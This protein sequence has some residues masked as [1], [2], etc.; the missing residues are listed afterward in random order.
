MKRLLFSAF[1]VTTVA[2]Q[3]EAQY[4]QHQYG[5]APDIGTTPSMGGVTTATGPGHLVAG[6]HSRNLAGIPLTGDFGI[7]VLRTD[8]GGRFTSP[9]NFNNSYLFT[10]GS[11]MEL[12]FTNGG[13][14]VEYPD[15]S[16]YAVVGTYFHETL[17]QNQGIAFIKLDLNGN[18]VFAKAYK[19]PF[20]TAAV[21]LSTSALK[22]STSQP[23]HFIA[24]GQ[25]GN[26][27][28]NYLWAIHFDQNGNLVWGGLYDIFTVPEQPGDLVESP[29]NN[30]LLI[31]GAYPTAGTQNAFMLVLNKITGAVITAN[32][33]SA[34]A[35]ATWESLRSVDVSNDPASPG[36][37]LA[38]I[39]DSKPWVSKI[40]PA[41]NFMWS[42]RYQPTSIPLGYM[43]GYDVVGR[44]NSLNRYEY[45]VTGPV[46]EDAYIM[47]LNNVGNP[48]TN[49]LFVYDIGVEETGLEVD[50]KNGGAD[51]G[52]TMYAVAEDDPLRQAYIVKAY[53]N[54]LSGCNEAFTNVSSQS[55]QFSAL[56]PFTCTTATVLNE[57]IFFKAIQTNAD[58][59][60]CYNTTIP[61]GSNARPE[62]PAAS[63]A[64]F[65][66][67]PLEL[68]TGSG[69]IQVTTETATEAQVM[70]CDMVGKV[71]YQ[72]KFSLRAG[73]NELP[74]DLSGSGM[75]AGLYT[76]K[77][78]GGQ[79]NTSI[80][81]LVK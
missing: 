27:M 11:G 19:M 63:G 9:Q 62:L 68:K 24:T 16:G 20:S 44:L 32:R 56:T 67:N 55:L 72:N 76:V 65:T 4:F 51:A 43:Y 31:V 29:Y 2:T 48:V 15:G 21:N 61:G 58:V 18:V 78:T 33:M 39:S 70:I 13:H 8:A 74:V 46:N 64:L 50:V 26:D 81:L 22:Q 1:F 14:A 60:F 38:G 47:K 79:L 35:I 25:Y 12:R 10:A 66:P 80:M 59:E 23:N 3:V 6:N 17:Q 42:R 57:P 41:R 54:G 52:V 71:Y 5:F 37:I 53:F 30:E 7:Y 40:G 75:A 34:G 28:S 45:Y 49:G 69:K 77:I 36:F 73:S